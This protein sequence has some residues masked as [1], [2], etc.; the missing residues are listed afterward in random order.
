MDMNKALVILFILVLAASSLT[1]VVAAQ[2][3]K[4][5]PEFTLRIVGHSYDVSPTTTSTT[6]S[7]TLQFQNSTANLGQPQTLTQSS[8][9]Q[10]DSQNANSSNT[11]WVQFAI[12]AL[13][14]LIAAVLL[15]IVVLHLSREI[16]KELSANAQK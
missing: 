10:P 16:G 6:D 14:T 9:D 8:I 1:A 5:V 15:V 7:S 11:N 2:S 13:L 3:S 4:P 12:L